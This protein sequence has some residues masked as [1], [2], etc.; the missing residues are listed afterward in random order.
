MYDLI[1]LL[2]VVAFGYGRLGTNKL[3]RY[4]TN[5][6]NEAIFSLDLEVE[7]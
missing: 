5:T 6:G 7:R 1:M 2:V 4:H 3:P